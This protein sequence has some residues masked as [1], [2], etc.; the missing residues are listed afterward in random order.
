MRRKLIKMKSSS[1]ANSG[2]LHIPEQDPSFTWYQW[3]R[4]FFLFSQW[5]NKMK[6]SQLL[7]LPNSS[8]LQHKKVQVS[9]IVSKKIP[10]LIFH[11]LSAYHF[12]LFFCCS[13]CCSKREKFFFFITMWYVF[14]TDALENVREVKTNCQ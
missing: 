3:I 14:I 13:C 10:L 4:W 6:I 1:K 11:F 9:H 12:I 5:Q 8:C 7:H 2:R